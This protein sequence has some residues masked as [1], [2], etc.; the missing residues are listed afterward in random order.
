M[1]DQVDAKT[2]SEREKVLNARYVE[3]SVEEPEQQTW[4]E[5]QIERVGSA[6]Y[7]A[8]GE[9]GEGYDL[10]LPDQIEFIES[11]IMAGKDLHLEV[12]KARGARERCRRRFGGSTEV[13]SYLWISPR[14]T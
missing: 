4:E 11:E 10:V 14:D 3:K 12:K 2:V 1:P 5:Q 7:A 9:E 8:I 13:S 6:K